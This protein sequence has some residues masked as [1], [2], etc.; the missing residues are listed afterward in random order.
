MFNSLRL[1]WTTENEIDHRFR[2]NL[3]FDCTIYVGQ[4]FFVLLSSSIQSVHH[5]ARS[6]HWFGVS[7]FT[8][9]LPWRLHQFYNKWFCQTTQLRM[10]LLLAIYN[11]AFRKVKL[12]YFCLSEMVFLNFKGKGGFAVSGSPLNDLNR[13]MSMVL[14]ILH[15]FPSSLIMFRKRS[16]R[17]G[18]YRTPKYRSHV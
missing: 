16:L 4:R 18:C 14:T 7:L 6:N 2:P 12:F 11:S 3:G 13:C 17:A 1:R 10:L 9:Q 8:P 5:I 15:S